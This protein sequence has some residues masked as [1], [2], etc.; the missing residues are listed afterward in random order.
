MIQIHQD[1]STN[2][3]KLEAML[4]DDPAKHLY[5]LDR[6]VFTDAQLFELEMNLDHAGL[7]YVVNVKASSICSLLFVAGPVFAD[8][9]PTFWRSCASCKYSLGG[10]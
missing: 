8:A 6:A 10:D 3:A 4:Q 9:V 7:L 5:R 1:N 2:L